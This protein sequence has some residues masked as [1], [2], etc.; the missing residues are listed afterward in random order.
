[1][2]RQLKEIC[3]DH[4][5]NHAPV[6]RPPSTC[7]KILPFNTL[8]PPDIS[9]DLVVSGLMPTLVEALQRLYLQQLESHRRFL[10][11]DYLDTAERLVQTM[12]QSQRLS[13]SLPS[14]IGLFLQACQS[15]H[16]R[17]SLRLKDAL[18]QDVAGRLARQ[19]GCQPDRPAQLGKSFSKVRRYPFLSP[20]TFVGANLPFDPPLH[21]LLPSEIRHRPPPS[22]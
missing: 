2:A 1:M 16:H 17:F 18:L 21:P 12:Q 10:E 20:S 13:E 5:P 4:L 15:K 9:R 8:S 6:G 14:N 19:R 7:P 3:F 22:L 11:R